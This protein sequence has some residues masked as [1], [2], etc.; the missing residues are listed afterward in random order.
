MIIPMLFVTEIEEESDKKSLLDQGV[1]LDDYDYMIFIEEPDKVLVDE[2]YEE[3]DYGWDGSLESFS[4]R[5]KVVKK[6]RMALN[7][8]Y[9]GEAYYVLDNVLNGC[10]ENIWY[11]VKFQNTE[12][13][14]GVAY[15]A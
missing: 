4:S 6:K 5:P 3:E 15:H 10:Y 2:E 13:A 12:Y 8:E 9:L 11:K 14:V 1:S 7:Y